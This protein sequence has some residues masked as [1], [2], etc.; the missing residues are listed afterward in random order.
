MHEAMPY[1]YPPVHCKNM[2]AHL[3]EGLSVLHAAPWPDEVLAR[4]RFRS[5]FYK[6]RE[7]HECFL[8][9][10]GSSRSVQRNQNQDHGE[11][12]SESH[13]FHDTFAETM[14][15]FVIRGSKEAKHLVFHF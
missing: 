4:V 14:H 13:S 2:L 7:C 10:L 9:R 8:P 12:H 5:A 15:E 11:K 6:I 1:H 3:F